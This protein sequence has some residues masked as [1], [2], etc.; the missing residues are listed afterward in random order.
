MA[1]HLRQR[2]LP[3]GAWKMKTTII[4][5]LD[6][7]ITDPAEGITRSI[8]YALAGLGHRTYPE[9]DLLSYIG[10]PL[11]ITFSEL[12]QTSDE[13]TLTRAI[14]LYRERYIPVGYRENR[15]YD[16]MREVLERLAADGS[17]LCIATNKRQDIA[18]S[19]LAF[20]GIDALFTQVHGCDLD[21]TKPDLLHDIQ[22]DAA[23]S[24]RCMVM[25]GD[26][27]TD[28]EAAATVGMPSIGV[29]WGYGTDDELT[30]ATAVAQS[31]RHLPLL[32]E[33]TAQPC[34]AT[35]G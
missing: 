24:R 13:D 28:F 21:R 23:L 8:N 35:D 20:L 33:R 6:G 27:G 16:G 31:P 34:H 4:F 7:T 14:E 18:Q 10:P 15:L 19:V 30:M 2:P 26:R 12:I 9:A 25:V 17:P 29:A 32:I 1:V 5:D 11:S 22:S 3:R